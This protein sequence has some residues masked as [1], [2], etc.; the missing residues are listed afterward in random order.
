MMVKFRV[1]V[2]SKVVADFEFDAQQVAGDKE[3]Y[4]G[5]AKDCDLVIADHRISR[6]HF[7][8]TY[9]SALVT[10]KNISNFDNL[11]VNGNKVTQAIISESD[12]VKFYD[13]ELS[14]SGLSEP[15]NTNLKDEKVLDDKTVVF[16]Q[17]EVVA[18]IEQHEEIA[19]VEESPGMESSLLQEEVVEDKS[20]IFETSAEDNLLEDDQPESELEEFSFN[21]FDSEEV[22]ESSFSKDISVPEEKASGDRTQIFQHFKQYILKISGPEISTQEYVFEQDFVVVGRSQSK[23]HIV[24]DDGDVSSIHAKFALEEGNLFIEDLNSSNGVYVNGEKVR[25]SLIIEGDEILI[26]SISF[27]VGVR[28]EMLQEASGRLMPISE[29][30]LLEKEE[31]TA[32]GIEDVA[33]YS[34]DSNPGS[35]KGLNL[36]F[37]TELLQDKRRRTIVLASIAILVILF[38]PG[39]G[40]EEVS[41]AEVKKSTEEQVVRSVASPEE[42]VIDEFSDSDKR[43]FAT[44]YEEAKM[45][46][47]EGKYND[48]LRSLE[49]IDAINPGYKE[50]SSLMKTIREQLEEIEEEKRRQLVAQQKAKELEKIEQLTAKMSDALNQKRIE[51]ADSYL[52]QIAEINPESREYVD[53]ERSL[54]SVK[55]EIKREK[56]EKEKVAYAKNLFRTKI[57]LAR[58]LESKGELHKALNK[59]EDAVSV[60]SLPDELN[61][62]GNDF[63][64]V[65]KEKISTLESSYLADAREYLSGDDF[66]NAL[67]KYREVLKVNPSSSEAVKELNSLTQKLNGKAKLVYREGLVAESISLYDDAKSKYEEVL[68]VAPKESNYYKKAQKKLGVF[69][70]E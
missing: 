29:R 16:D 52:V 18:N 56:E 69:Y 22:S 31:T 54:A 62:E 59:V 15:V 30:D 45:L 46:F 39:G 61:S 8:I 60:A 12:V 58:S 47:S 41:D 3:L 26:G 51:L 17:S 4:L 64:K 24:L 55:Q 21:N 13:Y 19:A 14:V 20:E 5:R 66:K 10:I 57:N 23:C 7:V 43:A 50:V 53:M 65:L 48:A 37:I 36:S 2:N 49:A 63:Y 25:K 42:E 44:Y 70:F 34:E 35:G 40:E 32:F 1:L 67:E 68:Q 6:N 28:S 38:L 11:F 9:A 33:V 27:L